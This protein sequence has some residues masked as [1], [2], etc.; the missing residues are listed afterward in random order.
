MRDRRDEGLHLL[1]KFGAFT[2]LSQPRQ[3]SVNALGH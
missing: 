1:R 2:L 3:E